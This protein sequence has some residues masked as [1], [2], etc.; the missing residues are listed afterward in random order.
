MPVQETAIGRNKSGL[1]QTA[2][3]LVLVHLLTAAC[4]QSRNWEKDGAAVRIGG[5]QNF[6]TRGSV[7]AILLSTRYMDG[8][9]PVSLNGGE[10]YKDPAWNLGHGMTSYFHYAQFFK[11]TGLDLFELFVNHLMRCILFY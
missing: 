1:F 6:R 7:G 3:T 9:A 11:K 8:I 10:E 5:K 2:R 4:P